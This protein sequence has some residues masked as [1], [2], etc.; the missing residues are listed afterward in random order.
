VYLYVGADKAFY[1]YRPRFG[2]SLMPYV[3][4]QYCMT[5]ATDKPP[6]L[7][8]LRG[9][10]RVWIVF[11]FM[12]DRRGTVSQEELVLCLLD[13]MGQRIDQIAAEGASGY[14]YDLSDN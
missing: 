7:L 1:F 13:S 11:S 4:G 8:A 6:D 10:K 9:T 14:L 12:T 2:L 3:S 5:K